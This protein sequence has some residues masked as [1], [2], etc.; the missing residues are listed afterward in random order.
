MRWGGRRIAPTASLY[1]GKSQERR[2][3]AEG[4][5][6][7]DLNT[8]SLALSQ[9]SYSPLPAVG[10]DSRELPERLE[11]LTAQRWRF[12]YRCTH[13]QPWARLEALA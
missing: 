6:T 11:F 12:G 5:R 9:L 2:A 8:A 10:A 1:T 13:P 4:T 7:P 3:G